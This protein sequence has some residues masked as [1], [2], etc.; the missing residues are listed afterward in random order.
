M[1][2]QSTCYAL[3]VEFISVPC[4][5]PIFVHRTYV[6][7]CANGSMQFNATLTYM[8]LAFVLHDTSMVDKLPWVDEVHPK[9]VICGI[10]FFVRVSLLDWSMTK[11]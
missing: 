8:V 6:W 2:A 10:N 3:N 4:M 7:D 5:L 11:N 9:V 1:I